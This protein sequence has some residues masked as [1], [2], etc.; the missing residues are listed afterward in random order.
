MWCSYM[1]SYFF[2]IMSINDVTKFWTFFD[3]PPPIVTLLI[4]EA[5]AL[6]SQNSFIKWFSTFSSSS[7]GKWLLSVFFFPET[8]VRFVANC[9]GYR[10]FLCFH[11]KTYL[12]FVISDRFLVPLMFQFPVKRSSSPSTGTRPFGWETLP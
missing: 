8:T 7:P 2:T 12:I 1:K 5:L 11:A 3:P 10:F 4:T 6:L 9:S